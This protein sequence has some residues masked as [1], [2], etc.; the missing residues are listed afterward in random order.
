MLSE[1]AFAKAS[2]LVGRGL[3]QAEITSSMPRDLRGE[4]GVRRSVK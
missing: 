2:W 1:T 4:I 3:E